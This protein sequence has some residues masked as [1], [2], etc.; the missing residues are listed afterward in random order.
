MF[1]QAEHNQANR[2]TE[3][4]KGPVLGD[5]ALGD[6]KVIPEFSLETDHSFLYLTAESQRN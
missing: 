3:T 5:K 1:V 6:I 2:F 4:R